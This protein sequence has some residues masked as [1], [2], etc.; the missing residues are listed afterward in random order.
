[1]LRYTE[2][3]AATATDSILTVTDADSVNLVGATA[4]ISAGFVAGQDVLAFADQNGISGN[5]NASTGLLTLTGASSVTNYQTA[6]RSITYYN[7]SESPSNGSRTISYQV[8]DGQASNHASNVVTATVTITPVND[9]PLNAVP[10]TET[11][12][13]GDNLSIAGL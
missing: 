5:Y 13:Q 10:G 2:N 6:L 8:N 7:T 4:Q 3:Q 1:A 11:V 12:N 9:A